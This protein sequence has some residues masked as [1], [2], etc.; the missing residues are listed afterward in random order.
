MT[1]FG[2][3]VESVNDLIIKE[4]SENMQ[5]EIEKFFEI[6]INE[7][8]WGFDISGKDSFIKDIFSAY[9]VSTGGFWIGEIEKKI[10]GTVAIRILDI[11]KCICELKKMY[12]LP[13]FQG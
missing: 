1:S 9:P 12:V 4:F 7:R 3:F 11:P 13:D 5:N 10:I 8:G 6:V 2:S